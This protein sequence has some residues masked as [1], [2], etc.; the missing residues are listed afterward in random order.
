MYDINGLPTSRCPHKDAEDEK[1][2]EDAGVEHL[3]QQGEK[4]VAESKPHAAM[5]VDAT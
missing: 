5:D 3:I 2:A 4:Q 1:G